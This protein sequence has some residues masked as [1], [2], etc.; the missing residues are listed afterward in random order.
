MIIPL[1]GG[2]NMRSRFILVIGSSLLFTAAAFGQNWINL[3]GGS[4]GVPGNWSN[5]G[6]PFSPVFDLNSAL[7][8]YTTSLSSNYDFIVTDGVTV[9]SDNMSI[10]LNGYEITAGALDVATTTGQAGSLTLVGP[11]IVSLNEGSASG[12]NNESGSLDVGDQ[13]GTGQLTVNDA[14]ITSR[15]EA[16]GH[17]NASGLLVENGGTINLQAFGSGTISN[18]TFNDGSI[19]SNGNLN[20]NQVSLSNGSGIS[21]AMLTVGNANLDDSTM[22]DN[23]SAMIN[24]TVTL[25]DQASTLLDDATV[26]GTVYILAGTHFSAPGGLTMEGG[27]LSVELNGEVSAPIGRPD[28][29]DN[30]IL[31]FT[32]QNGFEPTIGEQFTIFNVSS[33]ENTGTFATINVPALPAGESWNIS[34]LYSTGTISVVPEPI[35]MGMMLFGTAG[36]ALRRRG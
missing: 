24:G 33:L 17:F 3:A 19:A 28:S 6:T 36:L 30:G 32:L 34:N 4:W 27:I 26:S 11:G 18:A 14:T 8:G 7:P 16:G 20:L 31:D 25:S 10:E 2:S 15:G 5:D 12:G 23:V 35:S 1:A 29:L 21:C 9:Q 13:G 22:H